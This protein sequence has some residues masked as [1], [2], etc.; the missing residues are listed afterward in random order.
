MK[1]PIIVVI[2]VM[3]GSELCGQQQHTILPTDVPNPQ[4][5]QLAIVD[6]TMFSNMSVEEQYFAILPIEDAYDTYRKR[7][8]PKEKLLMF[9]KSKTFYWRGYFVESESGKMIKQFFLKQQDAI[10]A[11]NL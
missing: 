4:Y 11:L 8:I 9:L 2:L 3:L 6:S 1:N 10:A 7:E 5:Q